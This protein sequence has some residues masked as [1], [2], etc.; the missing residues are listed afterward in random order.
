[1]ASNYDYDLIVIGSG[2]GGYVAAIRAAQLNLKTALIEREHLGG[3]CL[4]WGCIPKKALIKSAEVLDTLQHAKEFGLTFDNLQVDYGAAV[5]RSLQIIDRQTKGVGFLMRKNKIDVIEG[6]ARFTDANTLQVSAG[7]LNPDGEPRTVTAASFVVATGARA[8]DL[9]GVEA[10]GERVLQYRHAIRLNEIPAS[11]LVVGAG[12]IGME[13]SHI[14]ATYGAQVTIVE[15]LDQALPLEDA[16]VAQEVVRAFQKRGIKV[17]TSSRTEDFAVGERSVTVTIKDV[18]TGS[19]QSLEVEKVLVAIGI[20]PNTE[21]VGLDTAGVTLN[22][23]G[24][25]EIDEYMRTSRQNIYAIGDCTGKMPLAH[26]A[27]AQAIVAAESAAGHATTPIPAERYI[28]MPRCTFCVPQVASL[29]MTETEAQEAGY[30]INVGKFPFMPNGAA[31]AQG[32][33]SGFVKIVADQRYGEILGAHIVGPNATE[34]LPEL[35]LAQMME[36][37]PAEI[38][39]NVHAH[40]T[41]AEVVMEAAHGVEGQAIHM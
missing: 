12:P 1:M 13:L 2:P 14:Y 4:N 38:A 29:G 23:D 19:A 10:D 27:S 22:Q 11:M 28:F 9:P 33:R 36:L 7:P 18:N 30:P 41:L 26:V 39:H 31:Q 24:F 34:L 21:D 8:R 32:V 3:V 40:P 17:L 35:S 6:H 25:I 5:N 15:M 37:T 20:S 16:D